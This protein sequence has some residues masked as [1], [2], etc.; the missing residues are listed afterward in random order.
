MYI[1]PV[2]LTECGRNGS[3]VATTSPVVSPVPL[4]FRKYW[5]AGPV[6]GPSVT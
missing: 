5:S 1:G 6:A 3:E 2:A 4:V